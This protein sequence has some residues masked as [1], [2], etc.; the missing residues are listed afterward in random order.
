LGLIVE[1]L[2]RRHYE[3]NWG[4]FL[5]GQPPGQH[6]PL[7]KFC[8][9][10]LSKANVS[11]EYFRGIKVP[12]PVSILH[13]GRREVN[14][15]GQ[16]TDVGKENVKEVRQRER[17]NVQRVIIKF[18]VREERS[19]KMQKQKERFDICLAANQ[20]ATRSVVNEVVA[21]PLVCAGAPTISIGKLS[22]RLDKYYEQEAIKRAREEA[23]RR[24]LEAQRRMREE[25]QHKLEQERRTTEY[26]HD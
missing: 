3:Q 16:K 26:R 12:L 14:L 11:S 24:R 6:R 25:A 13:F 8:W 10:W 17:K 20:L 23:E 19:M 22:V 1:F 5:R 15:R 7:R 4:W 9:L 18:P 21:R 2:E